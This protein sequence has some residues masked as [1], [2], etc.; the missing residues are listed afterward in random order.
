MKNLSRRL[1]P[2]NNRQERTSATMPSFH[3]PLLPLIRSSLSD[4]MTENASHPNNS[5]KVRKSGKGICQP[6]EIAKQSAYQ[7]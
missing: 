3:D 1:P 7:T 4:Y 2:G 6:A 5:R